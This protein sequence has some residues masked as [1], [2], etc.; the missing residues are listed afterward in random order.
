MHLCFT[1]IFLGSV[2][3][4]LL[5]RFDENLAR[6]S[7]LIFAALP[8]A[9]TSLY[10]VSADSLTL[11]I[12]LLILIFRNE[13]LAIA[14]AIALGLQSFEQGLVAFG[15]LTISMLIADRIGQTP[16]V[17]PRRLIYIL[18]GL[19]IGRL[20]LMLIFSTVGLELNSGRAYWL[21]KNLPELTQQFLLNG[22][23]GFWALL[24]TGWIVLGFHIW[25][26]KERLPAISPV[27]IPLILLLPLIW[28]TQ[29]QTRVLAVVTFP[30]LATW[31]LFNQEFLT[32]FYRLFA[33]KFLWIWLVIPWIFVWKQEMHG[34]VIGYDIQLALHQLFGWFS[35]PSYLPTWPFS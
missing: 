12:I 28:L 13:W 23:V 34:T 19:V 15:A 9:S 33:K 35:V 16:L 22:S 6:T 1:L 27:L 26:S 3:W 24:G 18:I 17:S 14:A 2:A 21:N 32:S 25:I 4:V 30:L 20:A 8:V 11:L 7:L 10:W 5:K 31:W 29:D